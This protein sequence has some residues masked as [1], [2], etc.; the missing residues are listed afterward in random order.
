MP[1][2]EIKLLESLLLKEN[3]TV[4]GAE[5]SKTIDK[6]MKTRLNKDG[7]HQKYTKTFDFI[8]DRIERI[9]NLLNNL[10]KEANNHLLDF[11]PKLFS[12]IIP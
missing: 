9:N 5:T 10:Q 6:L 1:T 2:N 11:K 4:K 7:Q 8:K 12:K 3:S